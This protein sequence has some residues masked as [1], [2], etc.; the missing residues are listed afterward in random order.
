MVGIVIL[1]KLHKMKHIIIMGASSGIGLAVAEALL[2]ADIKVGLAARRTE[3]FERLKSIFPDKVEFE[4]IDIS[5]KDAPE[6]LLS[7]IDRLGGMDI[8]FHCSGIGKPNS[9]LDPDAEA[10]VAEVNVVG[11]TRMMATA[12]RYFSETGRSG[13]IAAITSVA[14]TDGIGGMS[15]YSASKSYDQAYI[16]ALDQLAR[17]RGLDISFTDIRPGWTS[18]PLLSQGADHPMMMSTSYVTSRVLRAI[19]LKKRVAV[20]DWRWNILVGLWRMV[21]HSLWTR[22]PIEM[23]I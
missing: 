2:T 16:T 7:L 20:V 19:A 10:E 21:P 18:T 4:S 6:R 13:Q 8:Y 23:D 15:A 3:E 22:L 1:E 5:R 17:R 12:F 11:F 9:E 14:G